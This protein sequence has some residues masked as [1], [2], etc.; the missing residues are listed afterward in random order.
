VAGR[1]RFRLVDSMRGLAAL[2]VV[3]Y[4]VSFR[5]PFPSSGL[6]QYLSQRVSGPPITA[7]VLF[8][9]ISGF[10][11][12]R[13]FVV[14][15]FGGEPMPPLLPYAVRR[16]ARIVPGY[17]VALAIVAVWLGYSYVGTPQGIVRYFG[18]LQLYGNQT[19]AGG[20]INVAWSLC[21]EVTF[22]ISLPLFA[23]AARRFA[24]GL[25]RGEML[26]CTAMVIASLVWQIA[27][28][29]AVSPHSGSLVLLLWMLPGSLDLFAAGMALAV[30]SVYY[31]RA[32]WRPKWLALIDRAPWLCWALGLGILYAE[33]KVPQD[34]GLTG[35]WLVTHALKLLACALLLTPLVLGNQDRGWLRR[36]LGSRPLVWLGLV[37]YGIYLWHY[38]LLQKLAP[39]LLG[40]GEL[41]TLVVVTLLSVAV[42]ALSYYL[43]ERPAQRL[44]RRVLGGRSRRGPVIAA[45]GAGVVAP[46]TTV[47]PAE[48]S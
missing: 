12:Y 37:S 20:G 27:I 32:D 4:H 17:W 39:H 10:V 30:A 28:T 21:V 9:L 3:Y 47:P 23:M 18:F 1:H 34:F 11:L 43:V 38:A 24:G 7:V 16:F 25:L 33:G 41:Y 36:F 40:H 15:R 14:A 8:F 46:A 42:G 29:Q 19:T 2:S 13:P 22:Y 45:A 48:G 5:F 6:T 26:V 31:E 35:W 44:A